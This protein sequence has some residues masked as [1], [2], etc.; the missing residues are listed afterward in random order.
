MK[1]DAPEMRAWLRLWNEWRPDFHFDNHVSDGGDWQY[2]VMFDAD[3]HASCP[4]AVAS[5]IESKLYPNLFEML[6]KDGHT[7]AV[8]FD[9]IDWRDPRSGIQT[10]N[11]TPRF[12]TGYVSLR[13]RPSLLVE[14]HALKPYRT[15][16]IGNY[17]LM[18]RTLE[19][20]GRESATLKEAIED[21]EAAVVAA[22]SETRDAVA[23]AYKHTGTSAPFT[24]KGFAIQ[25]ELSDVSGAV[26]TIYDNRT[27]VEFETVWQFATEPAVSAVPPMAYLVPP[28]W[29]EAIELLGLHGLTTS[30]L[31]AAREL[32]VERYRFTEV[33]F[34]DKPFE[35]RT[36]PRFKMERYTETRSFPEGTVV[37][38]PSQPNGRVVMHLLEPEAP[39][40]LVKWGFFNGIFEQKEYAEGYVLEELARK[41]MAADAKLRD[42]F[43]EKVRTDRAFAGDARARLYFFYQRSPFW[44]ERLNVYPVA[45]WLDAKE[46]AAE[47]DIRSSK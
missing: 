22:T 7:P 31:D 12:S 21:S 1:A 26:R 23:L 47:P 27:P 15:R 19:V 29:T 33:T 32:S 30:R 38:R 44:D 11:F 8:Y 41:M 13:N 2:D 3:V 42:E 5:W 20:V 24:F 17:N 14:M 39:D 34:A 9:L 37:V 16:V 46:G 43:L 18:A 25:R 6:A 36:T 28:E 40:S 10:G 4:P 35:G 45:R